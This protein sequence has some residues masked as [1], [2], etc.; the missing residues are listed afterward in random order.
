MTFAPVIH[1]PAIRIAQPDGSILVKAGK[2]ELLKGEDEITPRE[3]SEKAGLSHRR[4]LALIE[5]GLI[6]ARPLSPKKNS[7][8]RIPRSE[9]ARYL[10]L[11]KE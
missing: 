11:E 6:E 10:K 2:P 3:F 1:V 4:V 8:W 7:R 5:E 9:V